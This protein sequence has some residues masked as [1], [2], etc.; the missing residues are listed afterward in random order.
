MQLEGLLLPQAQGRPRAAPLTHM[1]AGLG[2]LASAALGWLVQDPLDG[3]CGANP[4]PRVPRRGLPGRAHG[5]VLQRG[6]GL[7]VGVVPA[8]GM[9]RARS[10]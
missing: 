10:G 5:G 4:H 1:T 2:E 7:P 8:A 3:A 6:A 9:S